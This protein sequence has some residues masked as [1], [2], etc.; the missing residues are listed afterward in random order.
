MAKQGMPR[1]ARDLLAWAIALA[2]LLLAASTSRRL[3]RAP[4]AVGEPYAGQVHV[5]RTSAGST[6]AVLLDGP[7]AG[8]RVPCQ[9]TGAAGLATA[10]AVPV[11]GILVGGHLLA[12]EAPVAAA[13]GRRL[14]APAPYASGAPTILVATA[15]PFD[16][17]LEQCWA[18]AGGV[19]AAQ[20]GGNV[21]RWLEAE[22]GRVSAKLR[23]MS[24]GAL[25]GLD[26]TFVPPIRVRGYTTQN[27]SELQALTWVTFDR[28]T[29]GMDGLLIQELQLTHGIHRAD[30]DLFAFTHACSG[31]LRESGTAWVGAPGLAVRH[32][33]RT[34]SDATFLH[35]LGHNMGINHA[36]RLTKG[37]RGRAVWETSFAE[38]RRG[39]PPYGGYDT[40]GARGSVMGTEGEFQVSAKH[41]LGWLPA[42]AMPSL[43]LSDPCLPECGPYTLHPVDTSKADGMLGLQMRTA[44][45]RSFYVSNRVR[46]PDGLLTPALLI[47]SGTERPFGVRV[48][49]PTIQA[50]RATEAEGEGS[51]DVCIRAGE[52]ILLDLGNETHPLGAMLQVRAGAG[53]ALQV[54]VT[55]VTI[56]D[57]PIGTQPPPHPR[58][59][60]RP[61]P[62]PFPPPPLVPPPPPQPI[63]SPHPSPP[64]LPKPLPA[65][66]SP[67]PMPPISIIFSPSPPALPCPPPMSPVQ[68]VSSPS[69]PPL[70]Q[71][72]LPPMPPR[73]LFPNPSS[74]LLPRRPP[75]PPRVPSPSPRQP[76]V[77]P[78][79]HP[80]PLPPSF[81]PRA[82][83]ISPPPPVIPPGVSP[84]TSL[85]LRSPP[86]LPPPLPSPPPS[87]MRSLPPPPV[88]R[89]PPPLPPPA[90]PP[91]APPAAPGGTQ[92]AMVVATAVAGGIGAAGIIAMVVYFLAVAFGSTLQ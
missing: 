75:P 84:I 63:L 20:Y 79:L 12:A 92:P 60:P 32:D 59:S 25:R 14:D 57:P 22:V 67:P 49:T 1:T 72:Q 3:N 71:P 5:L 64:P 19:I 86:L 2:L 33:G 55:R 18:E 16:R 48:L 29:S 37:Q 6:R 73:L 90:A 41:M 21:T 77:A 26:A 83:P 30:F 36:G 17:S 13:R 23:R 46:P 62:P 27:C 34:E 65:S 87:V 81:S 74:P 35:E 88:P 50:D 66:P 4:P 80:S 45:E 76:P 91:S 89:P 42:G 70:P 51:S 24:Y 11:R 31:G 53:K 7:R 68:L 43:A 58:S 39:T 56:S 38:E 44:V 52:S 69:L 47:H 85:P 61:T 28:D 10:Q 82:H 54:S 8:T 78:S 15:C 9:L 40:Y